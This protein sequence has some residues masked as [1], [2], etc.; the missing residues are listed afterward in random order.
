MKRKPTAGGADRWVCAFCHAA[1]RR[2]ANRARF[3]KKHPPQKSYIFG[4]IVDPHRAF[5]RPRRA[6]TAANPARVAVAHARPGETRTRSRVRAGPRSGAKRVPRGAAAISFPQ[7]W[8][9]HAGPRCGRTQLQGERNRAAPA[10][11][12]GAGRGSACAAAR[13]WTRSCV[14][15]GR[16]AEANGHH[17][18]TRFRFR[19]R[20]RAGPRPRLAHG[21]QNGALPA[22]H[23]TALTAFVPAR[24]KSAPGGRFALSPTRAC[25]SAAENVPA[26]RGPRPQPRLA[27]VGQRRALPA[28]NLRRAHRVLAGALPAGKRRRARSVLAGAS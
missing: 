2:W 25:N 6:A 20:G 23:R 27:H 13:R 10:V 15:P 22:G 11:N 7:Q 4:Q 17:A 8:L 21:G 5:A 16:A 24:P 14:A 1:P 9:R 28:G 18:R 19:S 12:S 26:P 3:R